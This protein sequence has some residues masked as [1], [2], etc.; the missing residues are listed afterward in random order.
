MLDFLIRFECLED[1]LGRLSEFLELDETLSV[2]NINAKGEH[3]TRKSRDYRAFFDGETKAL[4][5]NSCKWE[6]ETL[7]YTFDPMVPPIYQ[8]DQNRQSAREK[9]L[10]KHS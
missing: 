5:E 3:R 7:G 6:V 9:F 4:V 10:K 2:Q 8:P 1:D